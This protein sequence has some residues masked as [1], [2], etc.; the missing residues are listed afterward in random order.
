MVADVLYTYIYIREQNTT[1]HAL[2]ENCVSWRHLRFSVA[3]VPIELRP[4]L[5]NDKGFPYN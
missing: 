2:F 1:S 3:A 5:S 4:Y